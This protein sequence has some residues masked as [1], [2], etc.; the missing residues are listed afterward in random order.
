MD[1]EGY[2]VL[3]GGVQTVARLVETLRYKTEVRRFDSRWC[4]WNFSLTCS[5]RPHYGLGIDLASSRNKCRK[6]FVEVCRS[7]GLTTL[8]VST[9]ILEIWELQPYPVILGAGPDLYK[10]CFT[11]FTVFW[12]RRCVSCAILER[13][14][15][16]L[17]VTDFAQNSARS[18]PEKRRIYVWYRSL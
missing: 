3:R 11:F 7:E 15:W 2:S 10:D 1:M 6:C 14:L 4:H 16:L 12:R 5:F 8:I 17:F 13:S 18:H 9:R